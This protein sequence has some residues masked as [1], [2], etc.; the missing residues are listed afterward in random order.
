MNKKRRKM[1]KKIF[2]IFIAILLIIIGIV[3]L[4][5]IYNKKESK[6]INVN[7]DDSTEIKE[8]EEEQL[9]SKF[10]SYEN[11]IDD[12]LEKYL[13]Y[14]NNNEISIPHTIIIVNNNIEDN[15]YTSIMKDIIDHK[16]FIEENLNRYLAF[17]KKYESTVNEAIAMVNLNMDKKSYEDSVLTDVTK[18]D[19]ILVNKYYHLTSDYVPDLVTVSSKHGT[20]SLQK[21][22]YDAFIKMY[23]DAY[24]QGLYLYVA[25]PY[26]SYNRQ[27]QLYTNYVKEDGQ[28]NADTYSAR[29]G[30]SEHQTGLAFDLATANN[31]SISAFENTKEFTWV[32]EN[33][34][35]YGFILRYPK[36]KTYITGYIYEPWH[37]RY[38]GVDIATY[39]YENN[40]T[41][42][43][44][45]A[46]NI[47]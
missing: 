9:I 23:N 31:Y 1:K 34:H 12:N 18:G 24:E 25:S 21:D 13:S 36:D 41:F 4:I 7:I 15:E 3:T 22:T 40:L 27:N 32:K 45:Y 8:S 37:Y 35:K 39:I 2:K 19:L 43:E 26:R 44:Y 11:Y 42:E 14:Y 46:M 30:S 28:E 5:V 38:V 10:K 47:R 17:Q 20:G 16:N 33:A 6:K 29:P